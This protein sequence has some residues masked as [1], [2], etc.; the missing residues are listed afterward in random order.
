MCDFSVISSREEA[1]MRGMQ[2]VPSIRVLFSLQG[3]FK[4]NDEFARFSFFFIGISA[5]KCQVLS[6]LERLSLQKNS[7]Q[8]KNLHAGIQK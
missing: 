3:H 2:F 8:F 4:S 7:L 5:S 6:S 1:E